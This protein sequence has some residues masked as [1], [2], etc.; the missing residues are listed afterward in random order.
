MTEEERRISEADYN[1]I[2]FCPDT[3]NS[4]RLAAGTLLQCIDALML[5][6]D[7]PRRITNGFGLIRPPGHHSRRSEPEGFCIFNNVAIAAK[8]AI[9]NFGLKRVLVLDWDVHHGDGIQEA[10]YENENVLYISLHRHDYGSF[11]PTGDEKSATFVGNGSGRGFNVNI[12]WSGRAVGDAEYM[13]AFAKIVMPIAYEFS[14]ELVLVSAGFDAAAGDPLGGYKVSAN[15]FALMTYQLSALAGGRIML[16]LE[17]GYNLTSIADCA[18]ACVEVLLTGRLPTINNNNRSFDKSNNF[19]QLRPRR[20]S[21]LKSGRSL[22]KGHAWISL[23][24][25]CAIQEN[26]WNCLRGLQCRLSTTDVVA[27]APIEQFDVVA[28]A[29]TVEQLE[30]SMSQLST[31]EV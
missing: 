14:P 24:D 26:H 20:S 6:L 12:P 1:S 11:F 31:S 8:Y 9:K 23:R 2:Y 22:V 25:V 29:P 30:A 17:G 7:D 4:A 21:K 28:Q 5:P 3:E 27:Q 15:C 19:V 16:A 13:A 10:F 18:N